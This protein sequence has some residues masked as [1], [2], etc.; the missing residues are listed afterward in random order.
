MKV[1]K[2]VIIFLAVIG[3]IGG[4]GFYKYY[5]SLTRFNED[6]V[7]GNTVGNLYGNGLFCEIDGIVYF[8]NPNDFSRLYK[9]NVD[10]S[11]IQIVANDS[12]YFIN[13]DKNYL[14]YSR[15]ANRDYSQMGFLNVNTDSL[16]RLNRKNADVMILDDSI[17]NACSLSGNYVVYYRYTPETSTELYMVKIDGTEKEMLH[18][19]AIDPRC[20]V[21]DKLYYAGI[22]SD[23]NLH[24]LNLQTKDSTY[25]SSLNLWLPMIVNN[26]L[27]YMNLDDKYRVYKS[28]FSGEGAVG[29]TSY[30]TSDYNIHGNFLYYQSIKGNPDGLYRVDM[31]TGAET[32]LAE[33]Q[34]DNINITSRY[35]YFSD[36]YSGETFHCP[37]NGTQVELFNPPIQTIKE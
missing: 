16:C 34:F 2:R 11:D 29:L 14:Y 33:G 24:A 23:H 20:M 15:N 28:P 8:A 31:S 19:T 27:Y 18:H 22:E 37:V 26:E 10:E 4:L 12:V 9:M 5:S 1:V 7:N 21:R 25:V 6:G 30:G 35:V 17:C 32:L 13:A 3:I 36:F